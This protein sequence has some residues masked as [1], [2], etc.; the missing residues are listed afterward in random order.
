MSTYIYC[1]DI[2][3]HTHRDTEK[4]RYIHTKTEIHRHTQTQ[5]NRDTHTHTKRQRY[6]D[7]RR[8]TQTERHREGQIH[9]HTSGGGCLLHPELQCEVLIDEHV[10]VFKKSSRL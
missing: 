6:T 1:I 3:L 9:T 10:L 4:Q 8:D 7:T 5:R 2:I